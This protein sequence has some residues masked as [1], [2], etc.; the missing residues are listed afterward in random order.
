[1]WFLCLCV[2]PIAVLGSRSAGLRGTERSSS[3]EAV[4]VVRDRGFKVA[5]VS[6]H[7]LLG[8]PPSPSSG[9]VAKNSMQGADGRAATNK[10]P[11]QRPVVYLPLNLPLLRM[12]LE[13]QQALTHCGKCRGSDVPRSQYNGS[14]QLGGPKSRIL[15]HHVWKCAG[16]NLCAMAVS[17][18]ESVPNDDPSNPSSRCELD[19]LDLQELVAGNYSFASLQSP[20]PANIT[21]QT[22][23]AQVSL[24]T[25]LRNPLNQALSH[26]RH[27]Q[28]DYGLWS[29]F[30][31]FMEYGLCVSAEMNRGGLETCQAHLRMVSFKALDAFAVFRD[32]QQLRWLLPT[33]AATAIDPFALSVG[34]R[35][36]LN[37]KDLQAAKTRLELYDE[38]LILEDLH[39]RDRF[40]MQRYGW[41]K[42]NDYSGANLHEPLKIWRP[43]KAEVEL[44]DQ[45]AVLDRL[46]E[47]QQW[48]LELYRYGRELARRRNQ[49]R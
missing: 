15:F 11:H 37:E 16:A 31:A 20:M 40:E 36:L 7:T 42:L 1:M 5:S 19:S 24:V 43:A 34:D 9:Q 39:Q 6:S 10:G 32:N 46:R 14:R 45:P 18:G 35:P 12:L 3:D 27:A 33:Q 8:G 30:S 48:D 44:K 23:P 4:A 17:N 49:L 25:V 41:T 38:I 13:R 2:V 28:E 26:Y 21:A 29:N 47:V 22:I